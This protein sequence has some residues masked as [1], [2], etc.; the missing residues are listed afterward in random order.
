[1]IGEQTDKVNKRTD[2]AKKDENLKNKHKQGIY[3]DPQTN[4][5]RIFIIF[6]FCSPS[7]II[8]DGRTSFLQ[9]IQ[10][11]SNI[12]ASLLKILFFLVSYCLKMRNPKSIFFQFLQKFSIIWNI[13]MSYS[14]IAKLLYNYK[15]PSVR[16]LDTFRRN[17]IFLAPN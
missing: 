11:T 10:S 15:Y 12:V 5:Q 13:K 9:P 1:M 2:E 17:A 3:P 8:F 4:F 7:K 14:V 16:L 6:R